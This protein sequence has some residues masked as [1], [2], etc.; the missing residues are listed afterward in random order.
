MFALGGQ[1]IILHLKSSGYLLQKQLT[2]LGSSF[3]SGVQ[4]VTQLYGF[5]KHLQTFLFLFSS[6]RQ[7]QYT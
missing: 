3:Y 7:K 6:L 5:L 2:N 4:S 1:F